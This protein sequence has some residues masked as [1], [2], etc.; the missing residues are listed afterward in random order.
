MHETKAA[1]A[2][3]IRHAIDRRMKNFCT[4]KSC[5]IRSILD[6]P[7]HKVVLDYLVV[8]DELVLDPGEVKSKVDYAFLQY[9]N[10]D[11]FSGVMD[12][13]GFDKLFQVIKHLLDR[14]AAGLSAG[15]FVNDTIWVKSSQTATQFILNVASEF[16]VI[17]NISINNDKMVAIPINQRVQNVVL[18][19]SELPISIAKCGVLHKYLDI[20]LSTNDLSKSSLVKAQFDVKFFSNMV[21]CKT[22]S[23]KQFLY[24]V[25]AVFQPIVSYCTQFSFVSSS[26][27]QCW[28]AI[29]RKGFKSKTGLSWDFP[30]EVLY[31]LLL[32]GLKTFKQIQVETKSAF[33]INFSN[34]SGVVGQFFEH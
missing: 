12:V 30:N 5:M 25:S 6:R 15:A 3:V 24:L 19:I 9:V 28:D 4:D 16:F 22:I 1:K 2:A 33:V 23:N 18:K 34:A 26:I 17:N 8:D 32:Y 21:L 29:I 7:F 14:K 31:Y 20:F 10:D 13:I 27:C 11:A